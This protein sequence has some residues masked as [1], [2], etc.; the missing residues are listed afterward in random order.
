MT[1]HRTIA[2]QLAQF[3]V[4]QASTSVPDAVVDRARMHLL[5]TLGAA[6]AGSASTEAFLARSV[7]QRVF[8]DGST[9]SWAPVWGTPASLPATHAA[10]VNGIA[11]HAFELDDSGGCDHSGA[12]VVPAA[13]AAISLCVGPV[14]GAVLIEA[15]IAGYE[16]ARRV[17]TALGGYDAVNELGWHSTGTCGAF[18]A[19]VAASRVLRL[20]EER[21]VQAIGLAGSSSGGTWAFIR[22]GAMSKRMHVGRAAEIGLHSALLAEQGFTGPRDLFEAPW[23]GFLTLYGTPGRDPGA[24]TR[25]LGTEWQIER[26]TIKPYA[27]CRSTHAAIDTLLDVMSAHRWRAD[28]L[29]SVAVATSPL[30]A[31]MCGGETVGS[32]VAAQMSLR[33]SLAT[34]AVTGRLTLDDIAEDRRTSP[35]VKE[36]MSRVTV[37]ANPEQSGGSALPVLRVRVDGTEHRVEARVARGSWMRPLT[38]EQVQEKFVGLAA[39]RLPAVEAARLADEVLHLDASSDSRQLLQRLATDDFP[40]LFA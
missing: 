35:A 11:A 9:D 21:A 16:V 40:D 20:S 34:A 37:E 24:L 17:Q 7:A 38:A 36:L 14:P 10:F 23:G 6:L 30:I 29:E 2:E 27:S 28:D 3:L 25:S 39:R 8:G 4:G 19:A 22:E 15:V 1:E 32:P 13:L 26:A 31:D 5:D 18:G 12:V 33:F